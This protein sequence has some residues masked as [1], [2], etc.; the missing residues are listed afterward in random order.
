MHAKF[1]WSIIIINILHI[2]NLLPTR[3]FMIYITYNTHVTTVQVKTIL[4]PG[5]T[6]IVKYL[7]QRLI[8]QY[9]ITVYSVYQN[10]TAA[11]PKY[12]YMLQVFFLLGNSC[13]CM[14][15][16]HVLHC[17]IHI[18]YSFKYAFPWYLLFLEKAAIHETI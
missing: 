11:A 8:L 7:I 1:N 6:D 13:T 14:L 9:T 3:M 15:Q 5:T 16:I 4:L 2:V 18:L 10:T 12:L 17:V